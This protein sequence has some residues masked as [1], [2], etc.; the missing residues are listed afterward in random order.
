MQDLHQL[1]QQS[2]QLAITAATGM[3]GIGKTDLAWHYAEAHRAEYPGGIWWIS[4]AQL[5]V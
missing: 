3:G 4:T 5:V 1:L 2:E